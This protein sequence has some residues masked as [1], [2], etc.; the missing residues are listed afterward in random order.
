MS[1]SELKI[2]I[3]WGQTRRWRA[4]LI[5]SEKNFRIYLKETHCL[6]EVNIAS[7]QGKVECLHV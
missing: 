1:R 4:Y 2:L 6:V 7:I 5:A 3:A